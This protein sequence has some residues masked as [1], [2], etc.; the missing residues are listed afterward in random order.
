MNRKTRII[1]AVLLAA[2]LALGATTAFAE[3]EDPITVVNNLASF[4][5][6]LTRAVGIIMLLFGIVQFGIS[7]KN[8]DPSSRAN[9][10]LVVSGGLVVVLARE[11]LGL[12]GVAV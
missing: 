4:I 8:H 6:T 5:F 10:L 11:I 7:L 9:S 3:D 12:I 1:A 2:M